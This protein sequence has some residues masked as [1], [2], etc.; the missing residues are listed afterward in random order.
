MIKWKLITILLIVIIIFTYLTSDLKQQLQFLTNNNQE[1]NVPTLVFI[2]IQKTAGSAFERSIVRRLY[3]QSQPSCRCPVMLRNNRTKRPSIKLRCNCLRNN[4]PWL[5]SRFSVGWICG[6][7]ADWTTYHRCLP[8]KMN[9]EY[10]FN[11]R[12]FLYATLLREPIARFISEYLHTLRGAT[13]LSE[14]LSCQKAQQLRNQSACWRHTNLTDFMLCPFNS[15]INRQ[16]R[17]LSSSVNNCLSSSFTYSNLIDIETAKKNLQSME[18]FGL[19][20]YLHLSQ[21]LFE[22]TRFCKLFQICSFQSYLEQDLTNN[23]TNDYL[24]TNVTTIDLDY[25]R[26][27][28]SDDIELY[29]F[30]RTLFFQRTCQILKIAC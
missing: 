1:N 23:Q 9:S 22:Q 2:H 20:E 14:R 17:M 24:T 25:L 15:A 16:T 3:F 13:W 5:I 18:F 6:V 10:G 19:T 29:K 28:N 27:V 30:A 4:E 8:L 21:R 26:Q 11:K 7:H 12:K